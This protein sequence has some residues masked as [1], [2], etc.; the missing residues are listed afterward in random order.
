MGRSRTSI[1]LLPALKPRLVKTECLIIASEKN[2]QSIQV[3]LGGLGQLYRFVYTWDFYLPNSVR[4]SSESGRDSQPGLTLA[5]A[6]TASLTLS[7]AR[8]CE[9]HPRFLL[10]SEARRSR[11]VFRGVL[12]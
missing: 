2:S 11:E 9:L 7:E 8:L 5:N 1:G 10:R 3:Y 12:R 6:Q 4:R